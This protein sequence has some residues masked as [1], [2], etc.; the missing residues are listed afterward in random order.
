M[1]ELNE[2]SSKPSARYA[3]A[4]FEIS[5]EI[6]NLSEV[7]K[8]VGILKDILT[9]ENELNSFFRSPIYTNEDHEKVF[10]K[11]CEKLKFSDEVQNTVL[12]M[13]NKGRSF[14]LV[15]FT[16]DFLK[17]CSIN[18]NEL[19]V[20]IR[21]AKQLGKQDL[22]DMIKVVEQVTKKSIKINTEVDSSI[23]AGME[24]KIGSVLLD[25]SINSKLRN[26]KNTLKRG[27]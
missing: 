26:L 10:L 6:K 7:E 4:L 1:Q 9:D 15:D 14:D 21:T 25:S 19:T 27:L 2:I 12:L 13:I 18:K 22:V 8:E 11:I 17:L 23:I 24:I 5:V 3:L 16:K 20:D